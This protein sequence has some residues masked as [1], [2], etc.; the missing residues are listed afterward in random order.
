MATFVP[1][2]FIRVLCVKFNDFLQF[3]TAVYRYVRK[4]NENE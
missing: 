2:S 1:N 4:T 3:S